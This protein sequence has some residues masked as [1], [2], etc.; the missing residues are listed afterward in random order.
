MTAQALETFRTI[1]ALRK[2]PLPQSAIAEQRILKSLNITD[3]TAVVEALEGW[4]GATVA[5]VPRG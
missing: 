1:T 2:Y 4:D 3:F 5:S